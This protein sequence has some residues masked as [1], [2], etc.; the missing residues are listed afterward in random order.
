MER[1]LVIVKRTKWE[2][3]LVRYGSETITRRVYERQNRAYERIHS[4]HRRQ[5]EN[6]QRLKA[7]L[8]GAR[9]QYREALPFL[10][11]EAIDLLVAFG[12][13]NHFVYVSG[14]A[15][16]KPILGCN[17]DPA[18]STGALLPFDPERMIRC[19]RNYRS[20]DDFIIEQWSRIE[21]E[22][23]YPDGH[24]TSTGLCTSEITARSRFHDYISRYWIALDGEE[25]EE[26]KC[27]GLLLATGAGSTGWYQ[28][29]RPGKDDSV[30]AK[31]ADYFRAVAREAG[32]RTTRPRRFQDFA[33]PR[34]RT[35]QVVSEMDGE[36]TIDAEP[37]RT[38]DFPPGAMA[39][40][41]MSDERLQ[42]VTGFA[43]ESEPPTNRSD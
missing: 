40:F 36:I 27:S 31:D 3:D 19:L 35:L 43:G 2:R 21:C 7:E 10:Q 17:S 24:R 11:P 16:R 28:N 8:N 29:C 23:D 20:A 38:Y 5:I 25:Y 6:L 4:A 12:G 26:Q 42:V 34:G 41:R 9:F 14:F 39:R 22:I 37:D 18:S 13:D 33:I 15:G 32:W 30:F 1:I